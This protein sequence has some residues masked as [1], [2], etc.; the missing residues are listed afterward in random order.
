MASVNENTAPISVSEAAGVVNNIFDAAS[1]SR[2][3]PSLPLEQQLLVVGTCLAVSANKLN[4]VNEVQLTFEDLKS[5]VVK[6][7]RLL[8]LP[9]DIRH[10]REDFSALVNKGFIRVK[11]P[12]LRRAASATPTRSVA[13]ARAWKAQT[14]QAF[15]PPWELQLLY[16][17]LVQGIHESLPLFRSV[18][19]TLLK[20]RGAI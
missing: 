10:F 12:P 15:N 8:S 4:T 17:E 14:A 9:V 1:V 11:A 2:S 13:A 5:A 19:S 20:K 3:L 7:G 18:T 16:D 6:L